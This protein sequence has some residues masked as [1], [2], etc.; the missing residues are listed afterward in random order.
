M[1][2]KKVKGQIKKRIRNWMMINQKVKMKM[3]SLSSKSYNV[4]KVKA[5]IL[6]QKKMK[7]ILK[8]KSLLIICYQI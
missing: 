5:G 1:E 3:M 4:Q 7:Y 6:L 8:K 2:V